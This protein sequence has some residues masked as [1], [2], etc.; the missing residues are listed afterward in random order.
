MLKELVYI[1]AAPNT[2]TSLKTALCAAAHRLE[3]VYPELLGLRSPVI[4]SVH[5]IFESIERQSTPKMKNYRAAQ[6]G[7]LISKKM[8]N[9]EKISRPHFFLFKHNKWQQAE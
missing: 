2:I 9:I 7:K 1:G 5:L 4:P 6:E 8:E 3:D